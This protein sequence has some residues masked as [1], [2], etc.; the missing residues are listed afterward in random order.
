M[1]FIIQVP[2]RPSSLVRDF[3]IFENP[4]C[5][6]IFSIPVVAGNEAEAV[7]APVEWIGEGWKLHLRKK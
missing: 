6:S 7:Y 1:L 2:G 4:L 3:D 5:G